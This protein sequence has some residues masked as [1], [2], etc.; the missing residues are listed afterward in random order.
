MGH[1]HHKNSNIT[2]V[3]LSAL[4][5][6]KHREPVPTEIDAKLQTL[7][8]LNTGII[9]LTGHNRHTHGILQRVCRSII[10]EGVGSIF[11]PYL[12]SGFVGVSTMITSATYFRL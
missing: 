9:E 4:D 5:D 2:A 3:N 8:D 6:K 11:L 7:C 12:L 1:R 10:S